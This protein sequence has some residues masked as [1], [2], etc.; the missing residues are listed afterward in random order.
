MVARDKADTE[1]E[2]A[3]AASAAPNPPP[4]GIPRDADLLA[5]DAE[6]ERSRTEGIAKKLIRTMS[7]G[8]TKV[9]PHADVPTR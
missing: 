3:T 4:P 6:L 8:A 7:G 1:V 5:Y 9:A 2:I